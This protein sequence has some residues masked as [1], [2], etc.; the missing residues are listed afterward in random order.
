MRGKQT[1]KVKVGADG[2]L[3]PA[4]AGKTLVYRRFFIRSRAHPRAC[5]ENRD[6][7]GHPPHSAGSSPRMRGKLRVA[8]S[9]EF[10]VRLIPAHA[11]KTTGPTLTPTEPPAHPRACGENDWTDLDTNG[12]AGSSPRM[13]GK[14]GLVTFNKGIGGLIPAHAGKTRAMGKG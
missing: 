14:P 5:G 10:W 7:R 1:V 11:G 13:R 8:R 12:A 3:I 2:G 9:I 6:G 4:H